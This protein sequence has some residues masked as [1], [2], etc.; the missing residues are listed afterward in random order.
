MK[1]NN[2]GRGTV[3]NPINAEELLKYPVK[4][5]ALLKYPIKDNAPC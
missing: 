4:D 3:H 5:E 1:K 2:H